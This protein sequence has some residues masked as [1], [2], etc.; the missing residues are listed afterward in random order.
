[1][2]LRNLTESLQKLYEWNDVPER[3]LNPPEKELPYFL[4]PKKRTIEVEFDQRFVIENGY[5]ILPDEFLIDTENWVN[6]FGYYDEEY[7]YIQIIDETEIV[8]NLTDAID[9]KLNKDKLPTESGVY[10]IKGTLKIPY[11][12]SNLYEDDSSWWRVE[13]DYMETEI[14]W[15]EITID[16]K[17]IEKM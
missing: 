6:K 10:K 16:F 5:A 4:P 12:I 15:D 2:K 17:K 7:D 1:M 14:Y 3:P 9:N 8:E 11:E 13:T